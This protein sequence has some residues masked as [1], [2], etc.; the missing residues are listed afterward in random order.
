MDAR[1]GQARGGVDA[2]ILWAADFFRSFS[3]EALR[4]DGNYKQCANGTSRLLVI[5]QPVWPSLM[6]TSWDCPMAMGTRQGR[7]GR[8]G[9][10][11]ERDEAS[12]ADAA[13]DARA[14]AD[15][16]GGRAARAFNIVTT[17][18]SGS[19]TRPLIDDPGPGNVPVTGSPE[20]GGAS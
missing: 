13:V 20:V 1:D 8:G 5:P 17:S 7:A 14:G 9:G 19:T 4:L 2:E 18:G 11:H 12:A 3:G 15:R 6:I 10:L 16:R